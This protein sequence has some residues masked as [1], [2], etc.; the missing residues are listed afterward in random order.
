MFDPHCP[1][2]A[3]LRTEEAEQ[4]P[5]E[6]RREKK[7]H[8]LQNSTEKS[9][10]Y[11][12]SPNLSGAFND[13]TTVV[14]GAGSPSCRQKGARKLDSLYIVERK[15]TF[16][17]CSS[18]L[19]CR[20][21]KFLRSIQESGQGWMCQKG[22]MHF[23]ADF[24]EGVGVSKSISVVKTE[25]LSVLPCNRRSRRTGEYSRVSID[26]ELSFLFLKSIFCNLHSFMTF[27]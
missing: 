4:D 2:E 5:S 8:P 21:R 13:L 1:Q 16:R 25:K 22:E 20:K 11:R 15:T 23:Y 10:F 19:P 3:V 17:K 24:Q 12:K 26:L 27:L 18:L 6:V 14:K 7:W 9:L